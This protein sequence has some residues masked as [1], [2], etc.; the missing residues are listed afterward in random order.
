MVRL[1]KEAG[2]TLIELLVV[3]AIIGILAAIAIP[4]FAEYRTRAFNAR[5][6]S[7]LRN[8]LTGSEAYFVDNE[9]YVACNGANCE[10]DGNGG[11]LPG[12]VLSEDVQI[13]IGT[14]GNEDFGGA[15]CHNRGNRDYSWSSTTNVM[16]NADNGG[17]C[18]PAAPAA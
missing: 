18:N 11:G 14:I 17:N 12:F 15:S 2:F 1:N 3:I 8:S 9:A 13:D 5:S 4:Q 10:D 7:D 16:A 6:V